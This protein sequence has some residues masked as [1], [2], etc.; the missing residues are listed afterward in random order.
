M[1]LTKES[2]VSVSPITVPE[3]APPPPGF[4]HA[5][6]AVGSRVVHVSGQVGQDSSGELVPGGFA[7]QLAQAIRNVNAAV[8]A[9]GGTVSDIA[10]VRL[11]VK[12]WHLGKLD[13]LNEGAAAA[14]Q[15]GATLPESSVTLISVAG[16]F[17]PEMEV[18]IEVVAVL[19]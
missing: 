16:L 2:P 9:A 18:E 3:F 17:T 11:F 6:S 4:A 7:P 8:A 13:E 19:D 12:D 1:T 14:A 15:D 5:T 10:H